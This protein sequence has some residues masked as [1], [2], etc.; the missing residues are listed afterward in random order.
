[1]PL[2]IYGLRYL[3]VVSPDYIICIFIQTAW[4]LMRNVHLISNV[5]ANARMWR[6]AMLNYICSQ[7]FEIWNL[8]FTWQYTTNIFQTI[9]Y[10]ILVMWSTIPAFTFPFFLPFSSLFLYINI[11]KFIINLNTKQVVNCNIAK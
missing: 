9:A 10:R 3:K 5:A 4:S 7:E 1:M 8:L 11:L 6:A 2:Q